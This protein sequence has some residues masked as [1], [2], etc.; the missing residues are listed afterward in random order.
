[1]K[2]EINNCQKCNKPRAKNRGILHTVMVKNPGERNCRI[3]I[4]DKCLELRS[5]ARKKAKHTKIRKI[6]GQGEHVRVR[7]IYCG[8]KCKGCP[9]K[10]YAYKVWREGKKIKERYLGIC[11]PRGNMIKWRTR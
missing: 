4:C 8:K 10:Y 2:K 3:Q 11:D 5:V 7:P 1:M 6:L 9:H